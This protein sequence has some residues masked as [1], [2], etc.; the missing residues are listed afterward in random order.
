VSGSNCCPR[1]YNYGN[2]ADEDPRMKRKVMYV[3]E[4][5]VV[6]QVGKGDENCSSCTPLR[7]KPMLLN[8]WVAMQFH[9]FP[10]Y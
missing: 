5:G 1:G 8:V 10:Y 3:R 7:F 9:E 6:E 2:G 4:G